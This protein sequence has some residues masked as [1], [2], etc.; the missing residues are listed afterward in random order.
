MHARREEKRK[1][2]ADFPPGSMVTPS[3]QQN[4]A[5]NA[6]KQVKSGKLSIMSRFKFRPTVPRILALGYLGVILLGSFLLSLP[7]SSKTGEWTPYINALFTSTSATCVTGLIA[8]DTFMHWTAFG[9]VVII[10]LIQVGGIGF[11]TVVTLFSFALGRRI[12]LYERVILAQS[13]GAMGR[14]GVV[15][16]VKR[17]I[18]FTFSVEL[19]GAFL[20]MI[21]FIPEF[22]A[23]RG[24]WFSVFHSI[25]AFCNAGFDLMGAKGTAFAS[26]TSYSGDALVN[27]TICA[28]IVVGGMGYVVWSDIWDKKFRYRKY[29]LH[30]RIVLWA[31]LILVFVPALLIYAFEHNG[32]LAGMGPGESFLACLFQSITPRTAGFNTVP[33]GELSDST[34]FLMDI[35]ML[36]GGNS[37]STAGGIKVTTIVV[38]LFGLYSSV[39]GERDITIGKRSVD[40]SL[41]K[42]AM[43]L[44]A[45]YLILTM[46][47]VL[48]ICAIEPEENNATLSV[49][50]FECC[51]A[52]CTVGVTTGITP[53]LTVGSK[54]ILILLMYAGRVGV[55]TLAGAMMTKRKASLTRR[56]HE[57]ILIG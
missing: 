8:Y 7:I 24:I 51:S 54:I 2:K 52:I 6:E 3:P 48:I 9:Q 38:V 18:I 30:T 57:K 14:S 11:M 36:I 1:Q 43:S 28:L 42:Q 13:A 5:Q 19:A 26:L 15:R 40:L 4:S 17:I 31:T 50:L 32:V 55:L 47:A 12:G 34:L 27:L 44:C 41:V 53:S 33:L 23:G 21:R 56:P 10:L 39:R 45:I 20:L 46:L 22:G 16:L 49:V 35:L 25:S 29:R 37:G